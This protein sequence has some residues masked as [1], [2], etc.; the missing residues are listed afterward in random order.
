[1]KDNNAIS[2]PKIIANQFNTYFISI[3]RNWLMAYH[4]LQRLAQ[5]I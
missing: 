4:R 3:A 5:T 1:M 2:D